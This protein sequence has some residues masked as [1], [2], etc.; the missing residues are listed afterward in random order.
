VNKMKLFAMGIIVSLAIL[1]TVYWH[2]L[3]IMNIN[4]LETKN[5]ELSSLLMELVPLN[6]T[7]DAPLTNKIVPSIEDLENWLQED[8]TDTENSSDPNFNCTDFAAM[9]AIHARTQGYDMGIVWIYGYYNNT[10]KI[11][12]HA[13]NAIV[14]TEGLVYVE[15]QM[16]K[17]WC[18]D[19]HQQMT[20]G[21]IYEFHIRPN[22]SIYVEEITIVLK[23]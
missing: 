9:L 16:D 5:N 13:I 1:G 14:T 2:S 8:Q 4:D 12:Y 21:E 22:K 17:V 23:Y 10:N 3:Q 19:D 18:Y 11:F 6:I 20:E 15:P 7:L